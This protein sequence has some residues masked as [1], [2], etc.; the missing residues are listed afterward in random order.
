MSA[1]GW[2]LAATAEP[3]SLY[4]YKPW[5][6]IRVAATVGTFSMCL[7]LL[8]CCIAKFPATVGL[9]HAYT[10]HGRWQLG[11]K[12]AYALQLMTYKAVCS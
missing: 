11:A 1:V 9:I 6:H 3:V 7:L 8:P 2:L 12:D 5:S 10:A 4:V